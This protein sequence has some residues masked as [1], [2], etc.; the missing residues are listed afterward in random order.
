MAAFVG[1]PVP[2]GIQKKRTLLRQERS[3]LLVTVELPKS[4]ASSALEDVQD[5]SSEDEGDFGPQLPSGPEAGAIDE[6]AAAIRRLQERVSKQDEESGSV[7]GADRANW[8]SVALGGSGDQD[9]ASY[10]PKTFRRN[11]SIQIDK[12]WTETQS[13]RSKRQ[14]DEMMGINADESRKKGKQEA[15]KSKEHSPES[16]ERANMPSL[17]EEHM[18]KRSEEAKLKKNAKDSF[19]WERDVQ[20]KGRGAG[21]KKVAEIVSQA[22]TMNDRF[23]RAS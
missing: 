6:E 16:D 7:L 13:E 3:K 9:E 12:S 18:A 8:M 23:S 22:R 15:K 4:V 10:N 21:S 19:D 14:A 11:V 20:G 5:S 1:P 17:L 2:E